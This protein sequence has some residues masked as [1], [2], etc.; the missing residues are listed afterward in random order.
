LRVI[1]GADHAGYPLKEHLKK[2]LTA[3]RIEV[4]DVGAEGDKSVDYP[5]YA[6]K[7]AEAVS[8][9]G[10][11]RGIL[12]CG[13]GIGMAIT[14]NKLPGVRAAVGNDVLAAQLSREHNDANILALG[15]R[16]ID[17]QQAEAIVNVWLKTDFGGG[18]HAQRIQKITEVEEKYLKHEGIKS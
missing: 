12:V 7:V 11:E 18:R 6:E 13:S 1:I 14:A 15:A 8:S 5:D 17:A 4:A 9:G 3:Q 16:I 2:Y 10:Y